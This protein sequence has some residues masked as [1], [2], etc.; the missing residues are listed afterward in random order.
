M[1]S[2]PLVFPL[3]SLCGVFSLLL[4]FLVA[5]GGETIC[6][7]PSNQK[8][9]FWIFALKKTTLLFCQVHIW[10]LHFHILTSSWGIELWPLCEL[11]WF[12]NPPL[13]KVCKMIKCWTKNPTRSTRNVTDWTYQSQSKQCYSHRPKTENLHHQFG[14][15]FTCV[16]LQLCFFPSQPRGLLDQVLGQNTAFLYL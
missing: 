12:N 2:F 3:Y 11:L 4:E 9:L 16:A 15:K 6:S 7:N 1:F 8:T 10:V 14:G 13:Q 5:C